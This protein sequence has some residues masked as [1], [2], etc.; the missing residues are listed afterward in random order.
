MKKWSLAYSK[1]AQKQLEKLNPGQSKVIVAWLKKNIKNCENPRIIGKALSGNLQEF[2]RYRI[3]NY[4]VI[5]ELQDNRVL[6]LVIEIG[7]RSTIYHKA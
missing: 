6:I 1:R 5:V 3:G 2:W 7:H 4:R